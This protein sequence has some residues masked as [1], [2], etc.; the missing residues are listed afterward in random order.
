MTAR[1]T[2]ELFFSLMQRS[3]IS[4]NRFWKKGKVSV[5]AHL[6]YRHESIRQLSEAIALC[7]QYSNNF[8]ANSIF[9]AAGARRYGYPAT[10]EKGRRAL[11]EILAELLGKEVMREVYIVEGS[12]LSR[13]NRISVDALLRILQ[14][15]RPYGS[16]LPYKKGML[17]KSGTMREVYSYAGYLSEGGAAFAILL[18]QTENTRDALLDSLRTH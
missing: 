10:W 2:A 7:F 8:I 3:S 13:E 6:V 1:Y 18:N 12:G 4:V 15:F 14:L 17:L 9:L 11:N 5:G 16:L